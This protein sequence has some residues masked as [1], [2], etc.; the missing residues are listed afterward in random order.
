[1]PK[2]LV[3][4]TTG[5]E[6]RLAILEDGL[7]TEIFIERRHN[8]SIL[9]NIYKGRVV[10]VLPGMQAAF[11]DIGLEKNAFLYVSDVIKDYT[12]YQELF[13]ETDQAI[14]QLLG[15]EDGEEGFPDVA[16]RRK[17]RS[18]TQPPAVKSIASSQAAARSPVVSP[19]PDAPVD[20]RSPGSILPDKLDFGGVAGWRPEGER[21]PRFGAEILPDALSP[22]GGEEAEEPSEAGGD[23][24]MVRIRSN[25]DLRFLATARARSRGNGRGGRQERTGEEPLIADLLKEGQEILVQIAKEPIGKKGARIT[26]HIVL[27]GRYVVFMPT[28]NHVGVSRRIESIQERQRLKRTVSDLRGEVGKGFIVRTAGEGKVEEDFRQDMIYLTRLWERI[29]TKT[30]KGKAPSLIHSELNLVQRIIRDYL[31]DDYRVIRVDSRTEYE[32]IVEFINNFNPDLVK[33]AKL[34]TKNTPIFDAYGVNQEIEK[35]LRS[36]VWLQAGGYIVINQT[37]ALVAIDVNTGKYTGQTNSLEDTI[38]LTNLE[39]VREVVRQLRLRDLG[40]II[41]I[42]FIDMNESKNRQKVM[43]ELQKELAK[44]KAPSK[45]LQFNEFGLVAITRKRAK[46]SL[47]RSLCQP[48]QYCD[49]TGMTKSVRTVCYS[50]HQEVRRLRPSLGEG[51]ELVIRCHPDVSSALRTSEKSVVD[52]IKEM[53]GKNVTV[54]PDPML[55]IEKF[56]LTEK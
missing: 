16:T 13:E 34:Y 20:D 36:K 42:D 7:V 38:T 10:R 21:K 2:E 28:V 54:Q 31:S 5:L 1:M 52:E 45:I 47:E 53:T 41:I 32:R 27:P 6:T 4:N 35:A 56:Q 40:G 46:Q 17:P 25:P 29:R 15:D 9:G 39:A 49:G 22:V 44:D 3:V 8:R 18:R 23:E 48:C 50:I 55:H 37:E 11:V 12:D 30:E 14:E 19:L 24:S 43:A 26:S 51:K 33:K